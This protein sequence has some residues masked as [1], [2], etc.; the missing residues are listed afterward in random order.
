MDDETYC[1]IEPDRNS[2]TTYV[3]SDEPEKL[4]PEVLFKQKQKFARNYMV[5]QAIGQ[6]GKRSPP[7]IVR[8]TV[9]GEIY[10]DKCLKKVLIPWIKNNYNIDEIIFW[11][12]MATSHYKADVCELLESENIRYVKK[13]ENAPNLPQARPIERYW[14]L[15][16]SQY[17]KLRKKP[18]NIRKFRHIW[19]KISKHVMEN[20]GDTLLR[21]PVSEETWSI[22]TFDANINANQ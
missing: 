19:N 5:W 13:S 16:K 12:D 9:N 15:C 21:I 4:S 18:D 6:D 3:H 2:S 1:Y 17:S 10:R 14:F 8:G 20:H 22:W 7:V 11:P